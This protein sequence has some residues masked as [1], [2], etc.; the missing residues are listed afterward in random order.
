MNHKTP[1]AEAFFTLFESVAVSGWQPLL[2]DLQE[3]ALVRGDE[4]LAHG[5]HILSVATDDDPDP[6]PPPPA[7]P[8]MLPPSR[9]AP[10]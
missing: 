4:T 5:L 9:A 3:V 10:S 7:S 1:N 8:A 6:D 2:E